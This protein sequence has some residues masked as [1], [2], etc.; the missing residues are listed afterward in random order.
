VLALLACCC[1]GIGAAVWDGAQ[2]LSF[3]AL[4][5]EIGRAANPESAIV[6]SLNE[7]LK[8]ETVLRQRAQD[9]NPEGRSARRA[10]YL[11][12]NGARR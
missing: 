3:A 1:A 6:D 12:E 5:D 2:P 7:I 8:T 10:L 11:I 4:R 9:D